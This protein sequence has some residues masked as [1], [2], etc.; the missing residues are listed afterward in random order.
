MLHAVLVMCDVRNPDSTPHATNTRAK[1]VDL[2][3]PDVVAEKPMYGFE[4]VRSCT[5]TP[6]CPVGCG[7]LFGC[8]CVQLI[9][10]PQEL[11]WHENKSLACGYPSTA[12]CIF[13]SQDWKLQSER[14]Q[15][16]A[17]LQSSQVYAQTR[18]REPYH[19]LLAGIM[20]RRG[21]W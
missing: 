5:R 10:A 19:C 11:S 6:P 17:Q 18:Q 9:A 14:L 2:L 4:Q 12:A 16:S 7:V 15:V 21:V 3:T 20:L 8:L 1:L 13:G